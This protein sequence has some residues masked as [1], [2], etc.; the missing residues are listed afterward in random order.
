MGAPNKNRRRAARAKLALPIRIRCF[1][2][3]YPEE[4]CSTR[5]VSREGLYFVTSARHYLEQ[6]F[7]DAKVRVMRNFQPD[8]LTNLEETG[9]IV[10]VESLPDGK[11]GV[12]IHIGLGTNPEFTQ[13]PDLSDANE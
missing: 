5:N 12:A 3:N 11:W 1:E 4:I 13:A 7:R 9:R 6:Y 2:S 10:R 8:D